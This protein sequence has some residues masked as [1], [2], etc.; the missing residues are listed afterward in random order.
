VD[1]ILS[2]YLS[3]LNKTTLVLDLKVTKVLSD[4]E[5]L[6]QIL[7]NLIDN[8]FKFSRKGVDHQVEISSYVENSACIIKI[9][10]NGIG[11]ENKYNEN[12]FKIFNR[13]HNQDEY[14]GTGIGLSIVKKGIERINGKISA[15]GRVNGGAEFTITLPQ[16]DMGVSDQYVIGSESRT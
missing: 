6:M 13:L 4:Y 8:A 15:A 10:D 14:P 2:E 3:D 9:K 16:S 7:R 1:Q 5:S 12:I 11:F